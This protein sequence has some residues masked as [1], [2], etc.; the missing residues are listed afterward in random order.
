MNKASRLIKRRLALILV[1]LF[2][3]ESFAAV[4]GDNDGAAFITK[5]EFDSLKNNFQSQIDQYNTSIDAKIDGAVAA[6][7]A[8]ISVSVKSE[9]MLYGELDDVTPG[10]GYRAYNKDDLSPAYGD[11]AEWIINQMVFAPS[12][13]AWEDI[14]NGIVQSV[15]VDSDWSA[16]LA[17][18]DA[19]WLFV[20]SEASGGTEADM[21]TQ[22]YVVSGSAT[23]RSRRYGNA[24]IVTAQK[25]V[26]TPTNEHAPALFCTAD[27]VIDRFDDRRITVIDNRV[28]RAYGYPTGVWRGSALCGHASSAPTY[29]KYNFNED[30]VIPSYGGTSNSLTSQ[31]DYFTSTTYPIRC[32]VRSAQKNYNNNVFC[33]NLDNDS[34]CSAFNTDTNQ[35]YVNGA[36]ENPPL[37]L[38][39]DLIGTGVM[40]YSKFQANANLNII[41][42]RPEFKFN[43]ISDASAL[44]ATCFT[45]VSDDSQ[46]K[47]YAKY[48]R[49]KDFVGSDRTTKVYVYNGLPFY[50]ADKSG[51]LE[52]KIKIKTN[53]DSS[54]CFFTD[55]GNSSSKIKLRVKSKEF[56]IGT[57]TADAVSMKVGTSSSPIT[58]GTTAVTEASLTPGELTTIQIDNCEKGK[59]YFLRWYVDGF[60]Y[61]GEITYLGDG[62]FTE[63]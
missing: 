61:G 45:S 13:G 43:Q 55:P 51:Q 26:L 42:S 21:W 2:S 54:V 14:D 44:P 12:Q 20:P 47:M 33:W 25:G 5:A 50:Y 9:T 36:Y 30:I 48:L 7:L 38:T 63:T 32:L 46:R 6:Y 1:L 52:F 28:Y 27:G 41:I 31:E 18:Y 62:Y 53:Y 35:W 58:S 23:E 29:A 15:R 19:G 57:D 34:L 16:D 40:G 39:T 8:G 59:T 37:T 22:R 49:N 17:M 60:Q 56:N 10:L 24:V 11:M 3:I 4:V